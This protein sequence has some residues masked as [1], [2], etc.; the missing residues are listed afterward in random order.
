M[1][2]ASR[3]LPGFRLSLGFALFYISA[4]VLIPL[5]GCVIKASSLSWDEF[6]QV[7]SDPIA[8]AAYKLSFT[9]SFV[10]AAVNAVGLHGTD[11]R[12]AGDDDQPR[13]LQRAA[14]SGLQRLGNG[15]IEP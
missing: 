7:V 5:A 12:A 8:V 9:T 6:W 13:G 15:G 10:A 3:A 11:G 2:S 1:F 14:L 4:L